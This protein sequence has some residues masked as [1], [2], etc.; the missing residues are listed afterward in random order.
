MWKIPRVWFYCETLVHARA[1]ADAVKLIEFSRRLSASWQVALISF[2]RE[3]PDCSYCLEPVVATSGTSLEKLQ[4]DVETI[5]AQLRNVILRFAGDLA[6][7]V[8]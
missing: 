6:R 1:L 4:R 2:D 3:N 5:A 8:R 7:L